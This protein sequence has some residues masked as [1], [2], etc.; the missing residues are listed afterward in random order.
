MLCT[1]RVSSNVSLRMLTRFV[2]LIDELEKQLGSKSKKVKKQ[3]LI[4]IELRKLIHITQPILSRNHLF[5]YLLYVPAYHR[6]QF[7]KQNVYMPSYH[8]S[9]PE[10]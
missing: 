6:C 8:L 7:T 3:K 10:T 1:R 9:I 2:G 5:T 4:L